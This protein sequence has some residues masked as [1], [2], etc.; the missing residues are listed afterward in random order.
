[1]A[2]GERVQRKE[3][4]PREHDHVWVFEQL[5]HDRRGWHLG[6][7]GHEQVGQ[8]GQRQHKVGDEQGQEGQLQVP[9]VALG[10]VMVRE[11]PHHAP[12]GNDQRVG[13]PE[14]RLG[15]RG[16]ADASLR[17]RMRVAASSSTEA[18]DQ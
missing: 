1:M 13:Q 3:V 4:D 7:E 8:D 17:E 14:H 10:E 9:D 11:E 2:A 18:F 6:A 16:H 15:E 12:H 5:H